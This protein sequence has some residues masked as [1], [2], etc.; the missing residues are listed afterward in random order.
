[1]SKTDKYL[2]D[3]SRTVIKNTEINK[4]SLDFTNA[5]M[6]QISELKST[7][8][9]Y[10]PLISKKGWMLLVLFIIAIIVLSTILGS[11]SEGAGLMKNFD[12][13]GQTNNLLNSISNIQ[14]SKTLVYAVI[15][16]G[17]MLT[18]QV[19]VL[20]NHFNKQFN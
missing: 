16:F 12:L 19:T 15:F 14:I 10:K 5:V 9:A 4:P 8:I 18:I 6:G 11:S 7:S 13:S 3:L 17:L 20:K 1:M 2:D